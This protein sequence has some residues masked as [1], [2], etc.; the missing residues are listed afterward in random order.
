MKAK[1]RNTKLRAVLVLPAKGKLSATRPDG[2]KMPDRLSK[3]AK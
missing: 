3:Y 2:P 1:Y